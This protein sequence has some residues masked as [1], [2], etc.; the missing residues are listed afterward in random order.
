MSK[1]MSVWNMLRESVETPTVTV[2]MPKEWAHELMRSLAAA[3][4][5]ED[6][7]NDTELDDTDGEHPEPDLDDV[8]LSS[9]D[10]DEDDMF[11]EDDDEDDDS[12][13][14]DDE[15]EG[16]EE[17]IEKESTSVASLMGYQQNKKR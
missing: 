9:G 6:V 16:D 1:R 3:L 15:D 8:G 17:E 10:D 5:I 12:E 11:D 14:G 7:A 4:E 2:N 13:D